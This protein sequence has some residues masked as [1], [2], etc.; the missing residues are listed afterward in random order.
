MQCRIWACHI[1][2]TSNSFINFPAIVSD[3]YSVTSKVLYVPHWY[4]PFLHS[5]ITSFRIFHLFWWF[6]CDFFAFLLFHVRWLV[7]YFTSTCQTLTSPFCYTFIQ[8]GFHLKPPHLYIFMIS[9]FSLFTPCTFSLIF[10]HFYST[11]Y[12]IHLLF[13]SMCGWLGLHPQLVF[14][15]SFSFYQA[16]CVSAFPWLT[17]PV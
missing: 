12:T 17:Y 1:S 9:V 14:V 10:I 13:I 2:L 15:I 16:V 5:H 6:V 8:V 7:F 11:H 4:I 3:D